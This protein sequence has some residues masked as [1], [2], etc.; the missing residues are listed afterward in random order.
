MLAVAQSRNCRPVP[1]V[2][3]SRGLAAASLWLGFGTLAGAQ[4]APG[5]Y[6]PYATASDGE[7][8]NAAFTLPTQSADAKSS[9]D[10]FQRMVTHEQWEKAFQALDAVAKKTSSGFIDR[11]DG[12]LVPASL[13]VRGL[14]SGLPP[15][16][17]N[18]Y[19]LFYD[20]QATR[21]WDQ[22][23]GKAEAEN[24]T[25]I[26]ANHLIS[27]IGDR[28]A[29]RLGDLHF[30]RGDFEQAASAWQAILTYC[31]DSKIPKPQTIAKVATALARAR[32]WAE[33]AEIEQMVRDRFAGDEVEIGGRRVAAV[34]LL[35]DLASS[36]ESTGPVVVSTLRDDI[37]LPEQNE[38]LWRFPFLT[39]PAQ[40]GE[41][42]PFMMVDAYGRPRAND[43]LI[44]AAADDERVYVNVFGVEMAFDLETGKLVW[45]SGKLHLINF[46]Q[47]Q[48]G[49]APERYTL[50]VH[51]KRTWSVGRDPQ[52]AAQQGPFALTVR[53]SATGSEAFSSRRA[54]SSWSILGAPLVVGDV[55]YIGAQR[56]R[57]GRELSLLVLGASDGKLRKT[58]AIGNYA[59][60]QNQLY[61]NVAARPTFA[62]DADRLYLDTNAGALVAVNP[63]AGLIDWAMMYESPAPPA[64]Y[65]NGYQPPQSSASRPLVAGGMVF[66]KG[67]RS[68]RL[69][70]VAADGPKLT[71]NR[72]TSDSA[73][74]VG[75]DDERIYLAGEDLTA[76]SR[77]T[78]E[79]L[80]ATQLPRSA[81][82][83]APLMT[84]TRI[85]Q[86]TSRGVC[87]VD[88]KSGDI[89]RIFR[90]DDLG[91]L[92]GSL[93]VAGGK[94]ITVSNVAVTAYPLGGSPS[95]AVSQKTSTDP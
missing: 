67:M 4:V 81:E 36:A 53:D 3:L 95:A 46:Q 5:I 13:L 52:Q 12:V 59:V 79:L 15:A 24:L 82:W 51:G 14:L 38:P 40:S 23:V 89:L 88:K 39:K 42:N 55:V 1:L 77:K 65:N 27:S 41:A 50:D 44:P 66:A 35:A 90:G 78:Q 93:F 25:S 68:P 17:K 37:T 31:P 87:E 28:A 57:Q 69:V 10:E 60:D 72:P 29:D 83:T 86:F 2:R 85:Y 47:H 48:Q 62:L 54:L 19:R 26:V 94:L 20:A 64:G 33:F 76:Y 32:R 70:G 6:S 63:Q 71:W 9:V 11:G 92:G 91:S 21:L 7:K 75:V 30:E 43:F 34:R 84:A 80:W 45:R 49:A 61:N 16:G 74:L 8:P 18:A 22:A 56:N 58:I 73:M